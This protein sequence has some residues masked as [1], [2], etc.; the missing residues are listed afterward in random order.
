M[1]MP[2]SGLVNE[3]PEGKC[4]SHAD[5]AEPGARVRALGFV[6]RVRQGGPIVRSEEARPVTTGRCG[7]HTI[8]VLPSDSAIRGFGPMIQPTRRPGN[9]IFEKLRMSTFPPSCFNVG[10]LSPVYLSPP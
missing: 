6:L 1:L 2:P 8:A 10:K 7:D 4:C 5:K 3:V 9:A